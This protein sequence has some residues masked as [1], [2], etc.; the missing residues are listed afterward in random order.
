MI[1]CFLVVEF[2][3]YRRSG[4]HVSAPS[5]LVSLPSTRCYAHQGATQDS[6]AG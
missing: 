1:R 3:Q 5:R 2:Q 4:A 6:R